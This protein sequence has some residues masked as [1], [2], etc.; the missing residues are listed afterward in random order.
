[1]TIGEKIEQMKRDL[2]VLVTY[3]NKDGSHTLAK[4]SPS[5]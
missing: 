1:M 4:Y 5:R 3:F 2:I